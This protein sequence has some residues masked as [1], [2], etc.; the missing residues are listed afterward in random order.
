MRFPKTPP[1]LNDVVVPKDPQQLLSW[2]TASALTKY[3]HWDDLLHRDPP[4]GITHEQWWFGIK[5]QR[6]AGRLELLLQDVHGQPFSVAVV[7]PIPKQLHRIDLTLGGSIEMPEQIKSSEH[8]DRYYVSSLVEEA[9][10]SSQLEGATT[11]RRIAADMLRAGRSPRD[12]S[13]QM[14]LNNFLTMQRIGTLRAERLTPAIVYSL[15]R[16]VTEDTLDDETAAGRLRREN[17]PVVVADQYGEVFHTPPPAAQL[18][19]R[20]EAM[21]AFA[22]GETPSGFLHPVIRA[23]VLHF[24]LA[25]DHPFVDGNGRTARALFYWCMLHHGYWLFEFVSISNIILRGPAKYYRAFLHSE[26]DGNDLTYFVLY[27]LSVIER[28]NLS[29]QAYIARKTAELKKL[30][31]ELAHFE[32]LNHRQRALISHALR[33]PGGNYTVESHR[34]SN[35]VV[36]ET[37]RSDLMDLTKRGF[38]ERKKRSKRLVFTPVPDLHER[39]EGR[40]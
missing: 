9:I 6:L 23:I 27:H 18:A 11:T 3:L 31:A 28:A 24:W 29:L 36:Y 22:N 10:T 12:R 5:L 15:H 16:R 25:Y 2:F 17:E 8:K 14:I 39:L 19:E 7:P 30:E 13:E 21:C 1:E 26:T 38:L 34:S 35:D 37:A 40:E 32:E 20:M 4:E 33:H